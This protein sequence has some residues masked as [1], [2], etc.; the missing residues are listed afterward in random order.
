MESLCTTR[1]AQEELVDF[2]HRKFAASL[3]LLVEVASCD[4]YQRRN[5]LFLT[6]DFSSVTTI[7]LAEL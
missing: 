1:Y 3:A 6:V 7:V 2:F 5:K 4:Q